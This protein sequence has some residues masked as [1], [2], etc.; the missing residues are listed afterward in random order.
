[1]LSLLC[2]TFTLGCGTDPVHDRAVEELGAEDPR[3]PPGPLHRPGQPC[4]VCHGGAGPA[5]GTFILSGTIFATSGSGEVLPAATVRFI[6]WVGAQGS[7]VTNCAGNFF[8][9]TDGPAPKWPLWLRVEQNG[10]VADMQS[11]IF[12]EGSCNTCHGGAS[13]RTAAP[14]YLSEQPFART[15][16]GC[17]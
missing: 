1:M 4:G 13:P 9:R 2:T 16:A 7:T 14:V 15:D 6:D 3:V 12:R 5:K 11:A 17:P 10:I 8:V